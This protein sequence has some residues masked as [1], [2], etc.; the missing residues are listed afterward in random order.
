MDR[1]TPLKLRSVPDATLILDDDYVIVDRNAVAEEMFGDAATRL[2][3]LFS[4]A[5]RE[6][7]P[8][9]LDELQ[10]RGSARA[11]A[12]VQSWSRATIV[13]EIS[14]S[15][16]SG[17]GRA[18]QVNIHDVMHRKRNEAQLRHV[19][20]HDS[21]TDLPNRLALLDRLGQHLSAETPAALV[22][23]GIDRFKM[24]NDSLGY[25]AGDELLVAVG[26]RILETVGDES[27]VAH[28]GGDQFAVILE[29]CMTPEAALD[30]VRDLA[31]AV[32]RPLQIRGRPLYVTSSLG[33]ALYDAAYSDPEDWLADAEI[34]LA[35]A[36][37]QGR[38]QATVFKKSQ[39]AQVSA[40][41]DLENELRSAIENDEFELHYQPIVALADQQLVAFEALVRWRSEKRGLLSPGA[42]LTAL[43]RAGMQG[44]LDRIV[45]RKAIKQ[46]A[47]WN[48][49]YGIDRVPRLHVNVSS[50][51]F[52]GQGLLGEVERLLNLCQVPASQLELEITEGTLFQYPERVAT[53]IEKLQS[54]G[55]RVALDDF[56]TGFSSLSYLQRYPV[57]ALKIDR[58]F[59]NVATRSTTILHALVMLGEA[60]GM[61]LIAEG[62][63]SAE[64]FSLVSRLGCEFGQGFHIARPQPA[65]QA[66]ARIVARHIESPWRSQTA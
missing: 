21:L 19:A 22:W 37:R 54:F 65:Q 18:Y 66:A 31:A 23:C 10:A 2:E 57:D 45:L 53:L 46:L 13:S 30:A 17:D 59:I 47:E 7:L 44:A 25:R 15:R 60:M 50:E 32:R 12:E 27:R 34:A 61:D 41:L 5:S 36:K 20:T 1:G 8:D 29:Q 33:I 42:F 51:R 64:E 16:F 43:A 40:Q 49:L 28:L 48:R 14:I 55:V 4:P 6:A 9:L 52:V 35:R 62:I 38:D 24:V 63:E 56:G 39:R 58:S 3:D 11:E 26:D